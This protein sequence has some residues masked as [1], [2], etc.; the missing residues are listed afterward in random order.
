MR[1]NKLF[2][3]VC[4]LQR[5]TQSLVKNVRWELIAEIVND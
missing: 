4:K 2:I 5:H 3:L 1:V